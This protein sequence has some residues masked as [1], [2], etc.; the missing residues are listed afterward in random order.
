ILVDTNP[1]A[2][3]LSRSQGNDI[4]VVA[5]GQASWYGVVATFQRD[6]ARIDRQPIE[7]GAVQAGK[8]FKPVQTVFRFKGPGVQAHGVIGGVAACTSASA[9]F[10]TPCVRCAIG[11][12]EKFWIAT[13]R[14]VN[15]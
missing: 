6:V 14:S 8:R 2:Q 7:C 9:F 4:A 1:P 5:Q 3:G 10:G 15:E 12:Q 11:P 13:G